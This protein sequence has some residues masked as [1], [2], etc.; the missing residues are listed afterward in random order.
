MKAVHKRAGRRV[1]AGA[2]LALV[3]IAVADVGRVDAA[4]PQHTL[5]SENKRYDGRNCP[6]AKDEWKVFNSPGNT[7]SPLD[8]NTKA[9][10]LTIPTECYIAAATKASLKLNQ[11]VEDVENLSFD[12]RTPAGTPPGTVTGGA[13]RL[14]AITGSGSAVFMDAANCPL[15][16]AVSGG[17]WG[18]MDATGATTADGSCTIYDSAGTPYANTPTG[19]A[20]DTYATAHP[21]ETVLYTFFVSDQAGTYYIDRLALG[22]GRMYIASNAPGQNCPDESSC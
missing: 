9:Y 13:P 8:S 22:T 20:W 11:P 12:Y 4:G 21:G 2:C 15:P 6:Q 17:T 10:R 5:F 1:F 3:S 7:D 18:R 14:V 16:I 19:S